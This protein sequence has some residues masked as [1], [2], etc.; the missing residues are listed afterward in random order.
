MKTRVLLWLVT[1][2]A[3][4][5]L[6][7]CEP[8]NSVYPL[9]KSEDSVLDARLVGAWQHAKPENDDDK[10]AR[11]Y[12][13][14]SGDKK[15]YDFKWGAAGAKG[16]FLASARLV[17]L[18][19]VMFID[20]EGDDCKAS[21]VEQKDNLMAFPVI[22]THMM[23]RIWLTD[24]TL[25]IHFLKDDWVKAQVKAGRFPLANLDVEG[26]PI[27]TAK[28]EE[29]RKFMQEHA[30]DQEALSENFSFVRGK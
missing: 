23:G 1:V 22:S 12:F 20:F 28:T 10:D 4:G 25:E 18:G 19:N 26:T 27:L 13:S 24:Q 8:V 17:R 9:Y 16:G 3:C 14:E 11:W 15:S 7:G 29:L 5:L 30:E 21:D 6:S 2:L